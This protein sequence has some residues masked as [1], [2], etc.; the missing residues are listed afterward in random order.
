M[1]SSKSLVVGKGLRRAGAGNGV[2]APSRRKPSFIG[3]VVEKL[4][5]IE[6]CQGLSEEQMEERA[7]ELTD[8]EKL[9][10]VYFSGIA[11]DPSREHIERNLEDGANSTGGAAVGNP[12]PSARIPMKL[13]MV[14]IHVGQYGVLSYTSLL[15]EHY[16][17]LHASMILDGRI[18]L[19]WSASG[20]V[21][22]TNQPIGNAPGPS[23]SK[24][25]SEEAVHFRTTEEEVQFSFAMATAKKELVDKLIEVVVRYNKS[26]Y[27]HPIF[28]NCQKFVADS[29]TALGY[30]VHP[31]L[32]GKLGDYFKQVKKGRKTKSEFQSHTELDKY[33]VKVLETGGVSLAETEYLLSQYFVFHVMSM[34]ESERPEKW[35][36]QVGGG[37]GMP[38]L[39]QT[40]D[41]KQ[42]LAH[43]MFCQSHT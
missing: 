22:P 9:W 35:V 16:G 2:G 17:S 27:Y 28:R 29:V 12:P 20:L 3:D 43:N 30:P 18:V 14:P 7:A 42:T 23:S 24:K 13:R 32:E 5:K 39:E 36:C 31:K 41:L 4:R 21:V 25:Q 1:F 40:V 6:D 15:L 38:Q 37:C 34:T 19:S 33:V 10:T 26:Y 8:P 11:L